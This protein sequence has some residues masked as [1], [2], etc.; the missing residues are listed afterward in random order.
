MRESGN[1]GT[2][3]TKIDPIRV[4]FIGLG[5][6]YD[7]NKLAYIDN[8]GVNVV[9]LVDSNPARLV[10]RKSDWPR[11]QT[12]PSLEDL[13]GSEAS[14]DAVELLLP[15]GE[16]EVGVTSCLRAGWHVNTQKP[17]TNNLASAH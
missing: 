4:A 8:D 1:P 16:H 14:V 11:A 6:I 15:I 9:A 12:F 2:V 10:E 5:R 13:I 3:D 7:L 17:V